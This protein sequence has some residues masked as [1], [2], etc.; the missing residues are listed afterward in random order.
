[1]EDRG[2]TVIILV[3][4]GM[5]CAHGSGFLYA[6]ATKLHTRP[7]DIMIGASGDAGNVVY[8]CAGQS[9]ENRHIWRDLL[10]T[11]KFISFWRL[12]RIMD[13]DYLVDTVFK[14][15][16][17]L[18]TV[19]LIGS[20]TRWRIPVT[21][22]ETR[23]VR[24]VGVED[25]LNIFE[26][27]RASKAIPFLYHKKVRLGDRYYIDGAYKST[28][29]QHIAHARSLGAGRIVVVQHHRSHFRSSDP[30]ILTINQ[31]HL[32][33][34]IATRDQKRIRAAFDRGI[35]DALMHEQELRVFLEP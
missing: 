14:Q 8:F 19:N 11:P 3:G 30:N 23:V 25:K 17:P 15:Q 7:P 6:L 35:E 28:A 5:R 20:T 31:T 16:A 33:C 4:G 18:N 24:Y 34:G 13:I 22:A 21:D 29:E 26:T 10:S 27:L 1:M 2:K 12:S 32:H 9:E